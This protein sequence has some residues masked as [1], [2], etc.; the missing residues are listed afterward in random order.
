MQ[1]LRRERKQ[2]FTEILMKHDAHPRF[3]SVNELA[4]ILADAATSAS[5]RRTDEEFGEYN[6][7]PNIF[8]IYEQNI[9][10]LSPLLSDELKEIEKDY[11]EDGWFEDAVK[12]ALKMNVR[13]L[14]YIK[15]ILQ[16]WK[17]KGKDS[18]K[19]VNKTDDKT[20]LLRTLKTS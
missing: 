8:K 13:N 5:E 1:T 19:T 17:T 9:G 6:V 4:E 18:G 12:E 14:K 2:K 16:R 3:I 10:A 20:S 7:K 15:S 11:P